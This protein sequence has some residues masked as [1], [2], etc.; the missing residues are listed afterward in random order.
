MR[1]PLFALVLAVGLALAVLVSA[2][3]SDDPADRADPADRDRTTTTTEADGSASTTTTEPG[4]GPSPVKDGI[5]IEVLSSQPDRVTGPD[6]RIRVT[7][8]EGQAVGDLRVD[9]GGTD[10]TGQ[11]RP[12]D[13]ALEGVVIGFVEGS[14]TLTAKGG[15]KTAVQRIRSWPLAG[16]MI[17]GPHLPLLACSTAEHGLGEP[18]DADCN[19]PT[20][21]SWRYVSTDGSIKDLP[22]PGRG[23][24]PAD[25][26]VAPGPIAGRKDVPL[27]VRYEVGVLN[28]S[29]YEIATLDPSPGGADSDQSDADWNQRL[30]YR[31]GD[32]CG[33]T[34]G[35]GSSTVPALDATLLRQGYAVATAT[36]N[37]GAV[38]CND[39]LSAETT[40]MV[41]ERFVEEFGVPDL[42][43]GEGTGMGAALVHLLQQNYPGIVD[44]A[45]A[46]DPLPDIVT[47]W[48]GIGDCTLLAR[49]YETPE[50]KALTPDDRAAIGGSPSDQTCPRWL[51]TTG[52]LFDPTTGCDPKIAADKIYDQ[53]ARPGGVRCTLQDANANQFGRSAIAPVA[54]RPFDNVGVQYGLEALNAKRITFDQFVDLNQKVGGL[55]LDGRYQS[56]RIAAQPEE[57]ATAYQS[58]RV[59]AGTGDQ[60][61][62]PTIEVSRY[63]DPTGAV[64]EHFRPFAL[65]DRYARGGP[66]TSVPSF[67]V[68]TRPAADPTALPDALADLD[69]WLTKLNARSGGS[70]NAAAITQARP[71]GAADNCVVA[72]RPQPLR[73][74]KIYDEPGP[75]LDAYPIAGDPRIAAGGPRSDD[76]L[77][78]ELK[79]IDPE[80]YEVEL[81]PDQ[82]SRLDQVFPD[83]VCDWSASGVGQTAPSMTDRTYEDA[84]N[85]AAKA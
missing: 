78:C 24:L 43:I 22:D 83:G 81:S 11:L 66:A 26:A 17:S 14:S 3:S 55:D 72:G 50:G 34:F 62:L 69:Q 58:G 46:V 44:G 7:P 60:R 10:V 20:T 54:A 51:A 71:A 6:A 73:G 30:V 37:S 2:C 38:Q 45:V 61:K 9:L 70:T 21:V 47:V 76:V 1:R 23:A 36:F 40:M 5:R 15:G 56:K 39:V 85:P 8:A 75:C 42:T 49:Y 80:D 53:S 63:D 59:S 57:V 65:R 77:K 13:G 16:P 82:L 48:S 33:A 68:W 79:P 84:D 19:A 41:K 12:V 29:V 28:R 18:T 27:V 52:G 64:D 31:F 74:S 4:A 25:V 67:Q 35:Q 32:G